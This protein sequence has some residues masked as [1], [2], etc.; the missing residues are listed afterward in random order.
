MA[1]QPPEVLDPG[2][3]MPLESTRYAYI[4]LTGTDKTPTHVKEYNFFFKEKVKL[5][6]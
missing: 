3:P 1:A 4:E 5:L 2:D 6:G